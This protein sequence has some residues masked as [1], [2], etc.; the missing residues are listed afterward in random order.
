MRRRTDGR[1]R[2]HPLRVFRAILPQRA[3][4]RS[5]ILR[6]V[7]ETPRYLTIRL[8]ALPNEQ[9]L[10]ART[11]TVAREDLEVMI[12]TRLAAPLS[13]LRCQCGSTMTIHEGWIGRSHRHGY[14]FACSECEAC[15]EI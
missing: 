4:N 10:R 8:T 5:A 13:S 7:T 11:W 2:T 15:L 14:F 12:T 1:S 9:P 6:V 3:G